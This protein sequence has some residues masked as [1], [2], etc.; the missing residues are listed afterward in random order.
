MNARPLAQQFLPDPRIIPKSPWGGSEPQHHDRRCSR[1]APATHPSLE[2]CR[3]FQDMA[4][5]ALL[6]P[7]STWKRQASSSLEP[8]KPRVS[9]T[10]LAPQPHLPPPASPVFCPGRLPPPG[11]H[12]PPGPG[13]HFSTT[14]SWDPLPP[15][16]PTAAV[17]VPIQR[18][19]H[20][21]GDA[22]PD[23]PM[24]SLATTLH[25]LV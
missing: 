19:R 4:R 21:L 3:A 23:H 9:W 10:S 18:Q 2:P 14:A 1:R 17:S 22:H 25:F 16:P 5:K 24:T 6:L 7:S 12:T 11:P 15:V 8:A 13:A 20:C